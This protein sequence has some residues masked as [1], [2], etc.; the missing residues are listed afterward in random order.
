MESP[1]N[2]GNRC[3][4]GKIFKTGHLSPPKLGGAK[5]LRSESATAGGFTGRNDKNWRCPT[6]TEYRGAREESVMGNTEVGDRRENFS[7]RKKTQKRRRNWV[8]C[9]KTC[10][11]D[12]EFGA[13][14]MRG[15]ETLVGQTENDEAPAARLFRPTQTRQRRRARMGHPAL[16]LVILPYPGYLW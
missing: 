16:P 12:V 14:F 1:Q 11:F 15:P 7:R 5:E 3:F 6:C 10:C 4:K 8:G 9:R 2:I 13:L